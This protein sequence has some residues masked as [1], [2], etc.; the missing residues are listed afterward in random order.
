VIHAVIYTAST[1]PQP[2]PL[3]APLRA[4]VV[5]RDGRVTVWRDGQPTTLGVW[6]PGT[7][8]TYQALQTRHGVLLLRAAESALLRPDGLLDLLGPHLGWP[9]AVDPSGDHVALFER[10]LG[11]NPMARLHLIDLASGDRGSL[12][13]PS[14]DDF[15]VVIALRDGTV[16]GQ[17]RAAGGAGWSWRPGSAIESLPL[18]VV[19]V[20]PVTGAMAGHD[21]RPGVVVARPDGTT[22]RV[23]VS[24]AFGLAPGARALMQV[25]YEP[26]ALR[27]IPVDG[28]EPTRI[29]LPQGVRPTLTAPM[30]PVWETESHLLSTVAGDH[31]LVG[32]PV[33]RLDVRTGAIE[34]VPLGDV[35][36]HQV[37]LIQPL[38]P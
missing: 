17:S 3:G 4:G 18:R 25:D 28:G 2:L 31:R 37:V 33:V 22:S 36:P 19:A 32:A 11:R 38:L 8:Q 5:S 29:P 1:A 9:A 16:F 24:G 13:W 14:A 20:D 23:D 34:G 6:T 27:L 7:E 12:D 10:H 15:P 21:Q 30:A 35:P 26:P